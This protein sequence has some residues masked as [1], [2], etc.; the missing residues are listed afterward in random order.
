MT[1][2]LPFYRLILFECLLI[3]DAE[4][5]PETT[6]ADNLLSARILLSVPVRQLY[7]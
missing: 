5:T 4:A 1:C 3:A 2:C 7:L 6:P